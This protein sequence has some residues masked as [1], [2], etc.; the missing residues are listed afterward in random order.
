[1]KSVARHF[2]EPLVIPGMQRT[3]G[4]VGASPDGITEGIR[5]QAT[6]EWLRI[7]HEEPAAFAGGGEVYLRGGLARWARGRGGGNT[8][9]QRSFFDCRRSLCGSPRGV[10]D[11]GRRRY[12]QRTDPKNPFRKRRQSTFGLV[13]SLNP[14]SSCGEAGVTG[15]R[16]FYPVIGRGETRRRNRGSTVKHKRRAL[17]LKRVRL[18]KTTLTPDTYLT[19]WTSHRSRAAHGADALLMVIDSAFV[20]SQPV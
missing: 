3:Y 2:A 14:N 20:S 1:M 9:N 11:C 12:V 17:Q 13:S 6:I 19:S 8:P 10:F 7:R 18:R 4:I 15:W 16:S 5:R